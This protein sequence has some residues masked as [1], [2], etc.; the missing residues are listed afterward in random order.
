M[1]TIGS[2]GAKYYSAGYK[3]LYERMDDV[4]SLVDTL[5]A[6][7]QLKADLDGLMTDVVTDRLTGTK[8]SD[9]LTSISSSLGSINTTL[10][11]K[12]DTTTYNNQIATIN[13][14]LPSIQ[15]LTASKMLNVPNQPA[16]NVLLGTGT[17]TVPA[18]VN[19]LLTFTGG[20]SST[21]GDGVVQNGTYTAP[22]DGVYLVYSTC[23]LLGV[24]TNTTTELRLF[25]G[26]TQVQT[27]DRRVNNGTTNNSYQLVGLSIRQLVK[28]DTLKVYVSSGNA[29]SV[30]N[31][32][33]YIGIVKVA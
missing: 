5:N 18:N 9:T 10:A 16:F 32:E 11:T 2:E 17:T 12:L 1:A 29:T 31:T 25:K 22:E 33:T 7:V 23:F 27:L 30:D 3:G 19:T 20:G 13:A 15:L 6:L 14:T 28:G 26:S 8:L 4:E 24:P 21:H